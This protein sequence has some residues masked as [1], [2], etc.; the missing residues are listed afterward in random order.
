[1]AVKDV[2]K[3][4]VSVQAQYLE[5]KGDLADFDEAFKEGHITEE[6][7]T[8]VKEDVA[9]V[10]ENYNRLAYIIYLLGL[11]KRTS[12]KQAGKDAALLKALTDDKADEASVEAEN[13]GSIAKLGADLGD[14][15]AEDK[16]KQA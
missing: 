4:Y 8:A 11:R 5:M 6:K 9:K 16:A 13:E 10:E 1:M 14:L 3:Y 12:K 7:L 15:V 2:R